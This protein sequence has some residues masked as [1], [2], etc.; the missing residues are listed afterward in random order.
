MCIRLYDRSKLAEFVFQTRPYGILFIC[1]LHLCV[2]RCS[3]TRKI[4][5]WVPKHRN[6]THLRIDVASVCAT[7]RHTMFVVVVVVYLAT[8]NFVVCL[9]AEHFSGYYFTFLMHDFV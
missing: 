4:L 7:I 9:Q 5:R 1:L 2:L 6:F 3:N 8:D